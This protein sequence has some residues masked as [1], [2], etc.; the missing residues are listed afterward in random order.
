MYE[1]M[2]T[3]VHE[4]AVGSQF[5]HVRCYMHRDSEGNLSLE[6]WNGYDMV[7]G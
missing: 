6:S 7:N 3:I 5:V 2:V 1:N 4:L